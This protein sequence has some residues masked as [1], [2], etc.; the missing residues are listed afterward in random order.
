MPSGKRSKEDTWTEKDLMKEIQGD[1]KDK[2]HRSSRE[3]SSREKDKDRHSEDREKRRESQSHK[4]KDNKTDHDK[5]RRSKTQELDGKKLD[6]EKKH[7]RHKTEDGR[8]AHVKNDEEKKHKKHREDKEDRNDRDSE[9]KKHREDREHRKHSDRKHRDKDKADK[10]AVEKHADDEKEHRSQ[11]DKRRRHRGEDTE[12]NKEEHKNREDRHK[13]RKE[14]DK[15]SNERRKHRDKE[16]RS[17][18]KER[19]AKHK[20][21]ED[22]GSKTYKEEDGTHKSSK[23][24]D[25][26]TEKE[27][28]RKEKDKEKAKRH[29]EREEEMFKAL[30]DTKKENKITEEDTNYDYDD[31]FDDYDDDDFEEEEEEEEEE[32]NE[33]EESHTDNDIQDSNDRAD[34]K[35]KVQSQESKIHL[36]K[37]E[38]HGVSEPSTGS[39]KEESKEKESA[40]KTFGKINFIAASQKQLNEKTAKKTKKRGQELLQL[41]QL[42]V[43]SIEL[44]DMPPM[45][46]YE[47][48]MKRFGQSDSKQTFTQ[49]NDDDVTQE[50]QTDEVETESKWCQFTHD[51]KAC[52]SDDGDKM[53]T[54]YTS[55]LTSTSSV[56]L[57]KFLL[58]SSQVCNALLEELAAGIE[59]PQRQYTESRGAFSDGY[60][61]LESSNFLVLGR[62]FCDLAYSMSQT[63]MLLTAYGA[64]NVVTKHH[65]SPKGLICLW[66]TNE[67]TKPLKLLTCESIPMSCCFSSGKA[68]MAFAGMEDGIIAAWD[69][70]EPASYHDNVMIGNTSHVFRTATFTTAASSENH[71]FSVVT[72]APITSNASY[73]AESDS[74][75]DVDMSFQLAS[76]DQS[77][78][79]NIWIVVAVEPNTTNL[80]SV[81]DD[82]GLSPKGRIKLVKSATITPASSSIGSFANLFSFTCLQINPTKLNHLYCGTDQGEILHFVR[83]GNRPTPKSLK[84]SEDGNNEVYSIDIS[85]WRMPYLLASYSDGSVHLF[86]LNKETPVACWSMF[87]NGSAVLD[88]KWSRSKPN[89]FFAIDSQSILYSWD[90]LASDSGPI[91]EQKLRRKDKRAIG[92]AFAN[93]Y[94]SLGVG[95][96]GRAAE[97]A[98]VY[99]DGSV[100]IHRLSNK[101]CRM[102]GDELDR[103]QQYF[104]ELTN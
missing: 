100:E 62:N 78:V 4:E 57:N 35:Q 76:L 44:F 34:N 71:M 31:D 5:H 20:E 56:R 69:L 13:D 70:T 37:S 52:G 19:R 6:T 54:S 24:S 17:K 8:V 25:D 67:P 61:T 60:V 58:K 28:R 16:E 75:D 32:D 21:Q 90:L 102:S 38:Q 73:H 98:V 93:D 94:T 42:D 43:R 47:L 82:L 65:K 95:T 7:R 96:P 2:K 87:S 83:F 79:I 66:N 101:L 59:Q 23:E 49:T 18:E 26:Q 9:H 97:M 92:F 11:K 89:V 104:D 41:I 15:D 10:E 103:T 40:K 27:K 33:Q 14:H 12:E 55:N 86:N 77:G 48:Y 85:P 88:V 74:N 72:L 84:S 30:E 36:S 50:T 63:N 45:T 99:G 64:S 68:S 81:D 22:S 1:S 29:K 80:S 3:K 39:D 91:L 53:D 51:I 46:E